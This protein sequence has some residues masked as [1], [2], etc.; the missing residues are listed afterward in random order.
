MKNCL[1][2]KFGILSLLVCLASCSLQ[3]QSPISRSL[4][5]KQHVQLKDKTAFDTLAQAK[6]EEELYLPVKTINKVEKATI[7]QIYTSKIKNR[8]SL[9]NKT[10]KITQKITTYISKL[11]IFPKNDL[12]KD[13]SLHDGDGDKDDYVKDDSWK[14]KKYAIL[15]MSFSIAGYLLVPLAIILGTI[16]GFPFAF[17][18]V[19]MV[20]LALLIVGLIFSIRAKKYITKYRTNE[21]KKDRMKWVGRSAMSNVGIILACIILGLLVLAGLIL[22]AVIIFGM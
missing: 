5:V 20:A 9:I 10:K 18:A 4:F 13:K 21:D 16:L 22:I 6:K 12:S 8:E 17:L 2:T 11:E 1:F 15:G 7:S 19:M 14:A 3:R